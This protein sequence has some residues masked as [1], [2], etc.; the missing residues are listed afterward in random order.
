MALTGGEPDFRTLFESAPGLYLVLT[1][2]LTIVAASDAYLR[3]TMTERD[4]IVGRHLFEVFPD[5]PADSA[6][7]GERNLAASLARVLGEKVTDTMAVQKYDIR[8]P[9]GEGGGFEERYWSPVNS[10]VL[11]DDDEVAYVIHRVEDVTEFVRLKRAESDQQR[12][13]DELRVRAEQMEAE[14]FSR[15]VELQERSRQLEAVNRSI[16]DFVAVASHDFKGPLATILGYIEMIRHPNYSRSTDDTERCLEIMWRNATFLSRMADDLLTYSMLEAG[17]LSVRRDDVRVAEAVSRVLE[18][19]YAQGDEIRAEVP[20]SVRAHVDPDHLNR[21]LTNL[22]SNALKY[23]AQPISICATGD[24]RSV[25]IA[26]TDAG[27]GVPDEFVPRLFERF[28]RA[29][30][31]RTKMTRGAGLGLSIVQGLAQANG[32]AATYAPDRGSCFVI[33]LPQ[34]KVTSVSR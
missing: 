16:R 14:I 32:G 25:E 26:V 5:N 33:T 30:N 23:G 12:A 9:E 4:E 29:D 24:R 27:R 28:S 19:F 31:D 18:H 2:N 3:A 7:T 22:V 21:M 17:E 15:T 1:P 13:T 10:P 34:A 20:D 11:D 6:A 8:R